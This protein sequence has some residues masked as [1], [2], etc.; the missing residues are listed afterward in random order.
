MTPA[1]GRGGQRGG[2]GG[3]LGAAAPARA[4]AEGAAALVE[5]QA[6]TQLHANRRRTGGSAD[7]TTC[8]PHRRA[9]KRNVPAPDRARREWGT[10]R[11]VT[12]PSGPREL[13][14]AGQHGGGHSHHAPRSLDSRAC[15]EEWSSAARGCDISTTGPERRPVS[16]RPGGGPGADAATSYTRWRRRRA[17]A[18]GH[19][20]RTT[21]IQSRAHDRGLHA[22]GPLLPARPRRSPAPIGVQRGTLD[23]HGKAGSKAVEAQRR[24]GLG[25]A[26]VQDVPLQGRKCRCRTRY[27]LV[28]YS[29]APVHALP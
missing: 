17:G 8:R 16:G 13:R 23:G 26:A 25:R 12:F 14:L 9:R 29:I 24:A 28:S 11:I 19:L 21:R 10:G 7:D 20:G 6:R 1:T 18:D 22:A 27:I 5:D 4:G 2:A 3:R 15:M